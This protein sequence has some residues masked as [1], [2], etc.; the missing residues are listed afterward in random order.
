M[1]VMWNFDLETINKVNVKIQASTID[2]ITAADVYESLRKFFVDQ[3][4]NFKYFEEEAM[5]FNVSKQY[6][7]D[8]GKRQ[9]KTKNLYDGPPDEKMEMTATDTFRVNTFLVII[10]R[11]AS[12]LEKKT[13]GLQQVQRKVLIFDNPYKK[14][15]CLGRNIF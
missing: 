14:S 7:K 13:E 12:E 3:R 10:N 4:E 11:L 15:S 6:T 9:P 2:L 8:V 5:E 1:V